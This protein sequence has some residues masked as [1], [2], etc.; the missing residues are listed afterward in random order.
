ML[1]DD[2]N[3]T[4]IEEGHRLE[5][6]QVCEKEK[7]HLIKDHHDREH[8]HGSKK[9]H[10]MEK[11]QGSEKKKQRGPK[12]DRGKGTANLAGRGPVQ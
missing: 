4:D 5:K 10:V 6:D 2:E 1:H 8:S 11:A 3:S 7:V 9:D 12:E